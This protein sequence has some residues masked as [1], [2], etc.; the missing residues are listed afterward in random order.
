MIAIPKKCTK[1]DRQDDPEAVKK[2][3]IMGIVCVVVAI[4]WEV[5]AYFVL[6]GMA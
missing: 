3:R 5:V 4:I 2:T 1:K 6:Q